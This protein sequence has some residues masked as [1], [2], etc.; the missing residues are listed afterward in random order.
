[1]APL[2]LFLPLV[3]LLYCLLVGCASVGAWCF[4][5]TPTLCSFMSL[6]TTVVTLPSELPMHHT[7][8]H[9]CI[10]GLVTL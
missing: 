8:F 1:M 6:L 7:K 5:A 3:L 9:W 4:T 10:P 2:R